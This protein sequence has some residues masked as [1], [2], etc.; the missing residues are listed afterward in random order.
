M[1]IFFFLMIRR[2]PRPTRTDTLF[3]YTTLFRSHCSTEQWP[4]TTE[5][6]HPAARSIATAAL[7]GRDWFDDQEAAARWRNALTGEIM[8]V[9]SAS[10]AFLRAQ[11]SCGSACT[12]GLPGRDRKRVASGTSGSVRMNIGG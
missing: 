12:V 6:R 7:S 1:L 9:T 11:F 2:P 4:I 10:P 5:E 8:A 3:P